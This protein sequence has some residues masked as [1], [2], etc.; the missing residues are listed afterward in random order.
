MRPQFVLVFALSHNLVVARDNHQQLSCPDGYSEMW[1]LIQGK[2]CATICPEGFTDRGHRCM[3]KNY[4]RGAG[5]SA[6]PGASMQSR[7]EAD[8]GVGNCE[9]HMLIWY[10]KCKE[11]YYASGCCICK[12][13]KPDCAAAGLGDLMKPIE[14]Y[15]WS[16][17][18]KILE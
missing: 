2:K 3:L 7:C 6:W 12:P 10:P 9:K 14:G 18:K 16:C 1:L 13:K 4:G 17:K 8:Y 5:Y 15:R 11:G